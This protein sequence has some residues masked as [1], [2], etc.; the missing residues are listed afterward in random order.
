MLK[1]ASLESVEVAFTQ[2]PQPFTRGLG[3]G[4]ASEGGLPGLKPNEAAHTFSNDSVFFEHSIY[5]W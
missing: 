1:E 3:G 4:L 2:V 5:T